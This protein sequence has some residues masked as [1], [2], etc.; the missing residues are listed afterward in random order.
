M[1]VFIYD[2]SFEGLLTVVFE[3][4]QR[5][6]FPDRLLGPDDPPPLLAEEVVTV[7]TN[8]N[9][10]ARVWA[11]L[12]K[13][14]SR[15]A[16]TQVMAGWL[17]EEATGA[18]LVVRYLRA[19]FTGTRETDF[20]HPDVL[21]LQQL[22][23]AVAHETERLRQFIR[24]QKTADGVYFA[25]VSPIYNVLPLALPHFRDRF[26][27]QKWVLYDLRRGFGFYYDRET[28]TE[29]DFF[30]PV[31]PASGQLAAS[32]LAEGEAALQEAW[33]TYFQAVSIEER[34]NPRLQR[35]FMPKRF[36]P[37]LTEM[38]PAPT[39]KAGKGR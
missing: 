13:K 33:R 20:A 23:R 30:R 32:E 12:E 15:L 11:G 36:W 25:A 17:T 7:T 18:E 2:Q 10:A 37:L 28:I 3:A 34:A 6:A 5:R 26:A 21:A 19:V 27:D 4:F 29:I 38:Q 22:G 1:R 16:L 24:F 14:L 39:N 35:Q 9:Q 31:D 8:P